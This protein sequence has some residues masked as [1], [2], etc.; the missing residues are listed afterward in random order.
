VQAVGVVC[1]DAPPG[2]LYR[3]CRGI[4]AADGRFV[5]PGVMLAGCG[6]G[7]TG[8]KIHSRSFRDHPVWLA[9]FVF[10]RS[11]LDRVKRL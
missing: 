4:W 11:E 6:V 9:G 7:G 10:N 3:A 2:R 1:R 8:W 5:F